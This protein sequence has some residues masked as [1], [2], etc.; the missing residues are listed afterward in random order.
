MAGPTWCSWP[1]SSCAIPIGPCAP[2]GR[3][4]REPL[5]RLPSNTAVPGRHQQDDQPIHGRQTPR[6]RY[7]LAQSYGLPIQSSR[8][9]PA[10]PEAQLQRQRRLAV[11]GGAGS[12]HQFRAAGRLHQPRHPWHRALLSPAHRRRPARRPAS[13]P[14]RRA[15]RVHRRP[16]QRCHGGEGLPGGNARGVCEPG[17]SPALPGRSPLQADGSQHRPAPDRGPARGPHPRWG[18]EG[19]DRQPRA[20]TAERGRGLPAP[21]QLLEAIAGNRPRRS[22]DQCPGQAPAA[23]EAGPAVAAGRAGRAGPT[24]RRADGQGRRRRIE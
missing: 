15:D 11:G 2:P 21:A 7:A 17:G 19:E 20:R 10:R 16:R 23:I 13:R 18:A 9:H 24:A 6:N 8:Q 12:P 22:L 4:A 14:D 5:L 1:A 3:W